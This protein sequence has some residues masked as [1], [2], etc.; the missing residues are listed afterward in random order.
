MISYSWNDSAEYTAL[1]WGLSN[2]PS[3]EVLSD[4]L[5]IKYGQVIHPSIEK[6]ISKAD[7]VVALF[8]RNGIRSSEVNKELDQALGKGILIIPLLSD[9]VAISELPEYLKDTQPIQYNRRHFDKLVDSLRQFLDNLANPGT[10]GFISTE[11]II[12]P[13]VCIN[14]RQKI[15]DLFGK[16]IDIPNKVFSKEPLPGKTFAAQLLTQP[17]IFEKNA[18]KITVTLNTEDVTHAV[19]TT[20]AKR[21]L[22]EVCL[23]TAQMF[24]SALEIDRHI[25]AFFTTDAP[26]HPPLVVKIDSLPL[27]W[28]SGGVFPV[29]HYKGRDWTPFFFRDIPPCGW[30]IPLG[31][32]E[33]LHELTLPWSLIWREFLEEFLVL[34]SPPETE[35]R[36]PILCKLP[37]VTD[38]VHIRV[39][40]DEALQFSEKHRELRRKTDGLRLVSDTENLLIFDRMLTHVELIILSEF[41]IS[42]CQNVLLAVNPLELGIEV[43]SVVVCQLNDDDYLLDGEIFAPAGGEPQ[44]VRMPTAL[45]SHDYL[46]KTFFDKTNPLNYT[47]GIQPSVQA[48]TIPSRDVVLFRWDVERRQ[49]VLDDPAMGMSWEREHDNLWRQNFAESFRA[50]DDQAPFSTLPAIFTASSAKLASYYFA[51]RTRAL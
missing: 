1:V 44:L 29:V 35:S 24:E 47:S 38:T 26:D 16:G 41:G 49:D 6:M 37:H 46:R 28:A 19:Y 31:S 34:S 51:N 7:A 20:P 17:L 43:V 14:W 39:A 5:V 21:R 10:H 2:V 40:L 22:C 15:R 45:I 3:L 30:N 36:Q 12:E 48:D 4:R 8:T 50:H 33:A 27:R 32:S 18:G 25:H 11:R 13:R 23:S 9:D 42:K